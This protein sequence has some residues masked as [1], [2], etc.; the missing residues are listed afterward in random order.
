MAL[1]KVEIQLTCFMRIGYNIFDGFHE[2][3][4]RTRLE[5]KLE[6][7]LFGRKDSEAFKFIIAY[8][9]QEKIERD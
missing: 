3:F 8:E 9:I 1:S 6:L 5:S 2:A 4:Y 7:R